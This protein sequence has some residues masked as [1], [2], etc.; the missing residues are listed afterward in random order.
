M[1]KCKSWGEQQQLSL[2]LLNHNPN[3]KLKLE[4]VQVHSPNRHHLP[5][6]AHYALCDIKPSTDFLAPYLGGKCWI[7]DTAARTVADRALGETEQRILPEAL[8]KAALAAGG[9]NQNTT[10]TTWRRRAKAGAACRMGGRTCGC[11][12]RTSVAKRKAANVG[13]PVFIRSPAEL[14]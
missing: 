8:P 10:R 7:R 1:M 3:A 12:R 2:S 6:H 11:V 13:E 14:S 9:R 4:Q 5:V